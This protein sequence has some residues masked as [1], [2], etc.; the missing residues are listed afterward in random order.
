MA[1]DIT[2]ISVLHR[3]GEV[4][5]RWA[6]S[7]RRARDLLD[8][9]ESRVTVIAVDSASGDGTAESLAQAAPWIEL[10]VQR[11]NVGFSAGCNIG[12]RAAAEATLVVLMNPDVVVRDDFFARA[13]ALEW[14]DDLA[15]VG[16]CVLSPAGAVEQS[17]RAFP[18]A[19]TGVFGRTTLLSRW[20]PR[21]SGARKQL[22]ADPQLGVR[23]VDWVSGAC[24]IAPI[25]R[26]R[27]VGLLDERYWMYWEDA[28]WCRRA[29]DR[30]MRVEYHPELLVTHY[31]GSSVRSKRLA[32]TVAFHR[33]A[34]LYYSRHV[35]R[36]RLQAGAG[37]AALEARLIAKL[38]FD[39]IRRGRTRSR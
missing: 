11:E 25:A 35:A 16:P 10:L 5:F 36:S 18:T 22:L 6:E 9:D 28:D 34:A 26:F 15:A 13:L 2:V 21:S 1:P 3:G 12:L 30:G 32:A 38:G 39:A 7:L 8:G 37:R 17:A 24:L 19:A 27:D 20:F 4:V 29:R 33:S 31:Q 23:V 14:P